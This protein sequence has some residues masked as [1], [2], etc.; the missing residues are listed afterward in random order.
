[1][2]DFKLLT[3]YD[4]DDQLLTE[5]RH[6]I[7][8]DDLGIDPCVISSTYDHN[9]W[10][11]NHGEDAY[12]YS[13]RKWLDVGFDAIEVAIDDNKI[14]SMGGAKIYND[15]QGNRFL[16]ANMFYYTLVAYRSR[17][18]GIVYVDQGF[19]DRHMAFARAARCKGL[20][21]TIYAHSSKLKAMVLNHTTR[22]ISH[23]RSKLKYWDDLQHIGSYQF[24]DVP[25]EFFYYPLASI[26]FDPTKLKT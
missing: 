18:N 26:K 20:F 1:M 9:W 21:F 4:A 10:M 5:F 14:V 6:T 16:R 3:I 15:T 19:F 8:S 24:N 23:V 12:K 2:N 17:Y 11:N 22:R 13:D 25:Q 7:F